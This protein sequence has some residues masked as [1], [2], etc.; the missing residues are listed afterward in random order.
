MAVCKYCHGQGCTNQCMD[1]KIKKQS[2]KPLEAKLIYGSEWVGDMI[3]TEQVVKG[4]GNYD[5]RASL[6]IVKD[7]RR[8]SLSII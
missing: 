4:R 8:N 3:K 5:R 6:E 2:M 7:Q 1:E